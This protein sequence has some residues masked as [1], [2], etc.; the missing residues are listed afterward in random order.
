MCICFG[1]TNRRCRHRGTECVMKPHNIKRDATSG[2]FV[3]GT[4]SEGAAYDL[5]SFTGPLLPTENQEADVWPVALDDVMQV[6][7]NPNEASRA[8]SSDAFQLTTDMRLFGY[9]G[10]LS[11]TNS[12]GEDSSSPMAEGCGDSDDVIPSQRWVLPVTTAL[13][14]FVETHVLA[15]FP[16]F[17]LYQAMQY[18]SDILYNLM[19]NPRPIYTDPAL[20][21]VGFM[22]L[23]KE[24]AGGLPLSTVRNS[25][26]K[27]K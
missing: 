22:S 12:A 10:T 24:R 20:V 26:K 1:T 9:D 13:G 5:A 23:L 2:R 16:D 3:P 21:D 18:E 15:G 14:G 11:M 6:W 27:I 7:I 19:H 17:P 4:P 8:L 25:M